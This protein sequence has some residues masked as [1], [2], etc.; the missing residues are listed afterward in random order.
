MGSSAHNEG[1]GEAERDKNRETEEKRRGYMKVDKE[2]P[3]RRLVSVLVCECVSVCVSAKFDEL[4][5]L[6][7]N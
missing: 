6:L 7:L 2:L 1:K 4:V 3:Q 5:E